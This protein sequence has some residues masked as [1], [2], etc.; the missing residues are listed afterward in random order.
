MKPHNMYW[1]VTGFFHLA[2]RLC[3]WLRR[4]FVCCHCCVTYHCV[5]T[6][7]C[8]PPPYC[9]RL[10]GGSGYREQRRS[11][12]SCAPYPDTRAQ[13]NLGCQWLTVPLTE[14]KLYFS[15]SSSMMVKSLQPAVPPGASGS[16]HGTILTD[17]CTYQV[18]KNG[19]TRWFSPS[20]LSCLG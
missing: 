15:S 17:T 11:G 10:S 6:A 9:W 1:S 3:G 20:E 12:Q 16:P 5:S 4:K 18:F 2:F 14:T 13:A 8:P 19:F 7:Q